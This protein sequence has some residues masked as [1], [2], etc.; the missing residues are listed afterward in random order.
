MVCFE[1]VVYIKSE[2]EL[3]IVEFCKFLAYR[4]LCL[5]IIKDLSERS[6]LKI[7]AYEAVE[8]GNDNEHSLSV[9]QKQRGHHSH[10][11]IT[12]GLERDII[13]V[14]LANEINTV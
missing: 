7:T 10:K 9:V 6:L 14:A 4:A 13:F 3:I 1:T 12:D 5:T 8:V 2:T 11:Y